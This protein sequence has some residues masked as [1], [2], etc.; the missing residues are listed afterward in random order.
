MSAF[1]EI[2][3]RRLSR[4]LDN[5]KVEVGVDYRPQ[6]EPVAA[7]AQRL[8]EEILLLIMGKKN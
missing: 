2:G 5:F 4:R 6:V 3:I 7:Q 1:S 8:Q